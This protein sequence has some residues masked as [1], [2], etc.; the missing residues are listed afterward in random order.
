[1]TS[2]PTSLGISK[3]GF[4][5]LGAEE[6]ISDSFIEYI[7]SIAGRFVMSV[8]V[9]KEV[10][11]LGEVR[12]FN[13]VMSSVKYWVS[14]LILHMSTGKY[15]SGLATELG[16]L[17]RRTPLSNDLSTNELIDFLAELITLWINYLGGISNCVDCASVFSKL[18]KLLS[19][20]LS[21]SKVLKNVKDSCDA[22][23]IIQT[24]LVALLVSVG[25]VG[26]ANS[27]EN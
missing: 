2:A 12:W 14:E 27:I 8:N 10:R 21:K 3:S 16:Y 1:M 26:N 13:E 15:V 6:V 24:C 9:A 17:I 18:V 25:G 11:Y 23:L 20:D 4:E 5:V 19:I 7:A 22:G